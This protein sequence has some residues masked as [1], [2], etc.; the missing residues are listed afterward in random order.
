MQPPPPLVC[1][2][3]GQRKHIGTLQLQLIYSDAAPHLNSNDV[4]VC[5]FI[6]IHMYAVGPMPKLDG[7][8]TDCMIGSLQRSIRMQ[9]AHVD[10]EAVAA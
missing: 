2:R 4:A 5:S 9:V 3:A 6:E 8:V 1:H 10:L 7:R